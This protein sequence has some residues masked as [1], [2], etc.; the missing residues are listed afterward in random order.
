MYSE[1]HVGDVVIGFHKCGTLQVGLL[2]IYSDRI[3][4]FA[5]MVP[6]WECSLL[7]RY[8]HSVVLAALYFTLKKR[9]VSTTNHNALMVTPLM[10]RDVVCV[11]PSGICP[12]GYGQAN[13]RQISGTEQDIMIAHFNSLRQNINILPPPIRSKSWETFLFFSIIRILLVVVARYL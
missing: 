13:G 7:S 5:Q 1:P 10:K 6:Y 11:S 4:Q 2:E 8:D 3:A 12:T 9:K